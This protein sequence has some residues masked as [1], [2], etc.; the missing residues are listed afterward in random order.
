MKYRSEQNRPFVFL[1]VNKLV[2]DETLDDFVFIFLGKDIQFLVRIHGDR[3]Y[4]AGS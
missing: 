3:F 2:R 4:N 1:D